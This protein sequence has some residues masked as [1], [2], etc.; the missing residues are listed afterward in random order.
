MNS[1]A[2][3]IH[4][5]ILTRFLKYAM[6]QSV[7]VKVLRCAKSYRDKGSPLRRGRGE[8]RGGRRRGSGRG[9]KEV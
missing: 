1:Y 8:V 2:F 7:A 4:T 3:K 9:E 5:S 6:L